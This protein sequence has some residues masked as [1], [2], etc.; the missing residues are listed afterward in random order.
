MKGCFISGVRKQ[1]KYYT[2]GEKQIE[3]YN[4]TAVS[5]E[6][7]YLPLKLYI[8]DGIKRV[9]YHWFFDPPTNEPIEY[10]IE[11][12]TQLLKWEHGVSARFSYQ[13]NITYTNTDDDTLSDTYTFLYKENNE[14]KVTTGHVTITYGYRW[15]SFEFVSDDFIIQDKDNSITCNITCKVNEITNN[16]YCNIIGW[17]VER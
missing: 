5:G 8:S 2:S 3:A 1:N 12:E 13:K 16:G 10:H 7:V 15:C 14:S 17:T 4:R 6:S 11:F 9:Y